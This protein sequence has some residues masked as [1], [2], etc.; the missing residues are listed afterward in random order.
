MNTAC[1]MFPRWQPIPLDETINP[2]E[3]GLHSIELLGYVLE[4]VALA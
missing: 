4:G 2:L 3:P 1:L